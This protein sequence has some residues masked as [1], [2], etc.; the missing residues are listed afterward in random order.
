MRCD[1]FE[2][3]KPLPIK[4]MSGRPKTKRVRALNEKMQKS[5]SLYRKLS[6][7]GTKQICDNCQME[8]HNRKSC[9]IQM[10]QICKI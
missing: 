10:P 9:S 4:H 6:R 3:I 8:G 1:R 2:E 7:S 5:E